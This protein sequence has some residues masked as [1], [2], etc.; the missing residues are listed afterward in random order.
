MIHCALAIAGTDPS[1]GA[2]IQADLKTFQESGVYGMTAITSLVA[3]NTTGVQSVY[4]PPSDFLKE[5]LSSVQSDMPIH[6]VKSGMIATPHMVEVVAEAVQRMN[7]P[8]VIDPV[9]VAQSGDSLIE[10]KTVQAFKEQLMPLGT[11]ITPNLPEAETLLSV[12]IHSEDDMKEAAVQMVKQFGLHAALIKGG[13]AEGKAVDVLYDGHHLRTFEAERIDTTNTHGTGCTYSAAITAYLSK[14]FP[15]HEA[16]AES[17]T[18]VTEA[19]RH[20]FDLGRGSGPTNHFALR[21]GVFS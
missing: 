1:G 20:S 10:E 11:L 19:I 3:Q 21:K 18:F 2:G 13:H 16:V 7:A 15:L 5:Q 9:M 4:H 12:T 8:Y 14:G 17:K 6:A